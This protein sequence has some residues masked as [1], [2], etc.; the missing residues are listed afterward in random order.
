VFERDRFRCV[1]APD[2]PD[3]CHGALHGHHLDPDADP[4]DEHNVVT[5]CASHHAKWEAE[6]RRGFARSEA[7]RLRERRARSV[8]LRVRLARAG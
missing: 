7:E 5:A 1:V 6:R 2:H 3:R 8:R 4:Y